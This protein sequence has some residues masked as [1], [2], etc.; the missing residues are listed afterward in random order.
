VP[1]FGPARLKALALV[2]PL[3]L[4]LLVFV[5]AP[6]GF[7]LA[8][9]VFRYDNFQVIPAFTLENY[10]DVLQSHLTLSLYLTMLKPA[11]LT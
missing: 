7:V 8:V 6:L 10:A 2:L 11:A 1:A 9:S 3:A 4:V 5:V